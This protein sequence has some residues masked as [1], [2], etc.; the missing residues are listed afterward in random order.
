MDE[1]DDK[2]LAHHHLDPSS[3]QLL[4][5]DLVQLVS[6]VGDVEKEQGGTWHAYDTTNLCRRA[7]A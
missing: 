5:A 2:L 1:A 6:D 7:C 4:P 3:G